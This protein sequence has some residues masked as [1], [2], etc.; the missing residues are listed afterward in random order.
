MV[1]KLVGNW[2]RG[3]SEGGLG[4][5]RNKEKARELRFLHM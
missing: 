3:F 5:L 2:P 4:G 1:L